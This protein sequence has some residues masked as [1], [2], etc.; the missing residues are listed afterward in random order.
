MPLLAVSGESNLLNESI[1][2]G[3]P[4]ERRAAQERELLRGVSLYIHSSTQ[5]PRVNKGRAELM[6]IRNTGG[7]QVCLLRCRLESSR[8]W[9]SLDTG[10]Q[11][12][13]STT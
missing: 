6:I 8:I 10:E 5:V 9:Q 13:R 1:A 7:P 2:R 12:H 3:F 11:A 4:G